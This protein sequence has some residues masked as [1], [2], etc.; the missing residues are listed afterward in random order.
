[1]IKDCVVIIPV[2]KSEMSANERISFKQNLA[3]LRQWDIYIITYE[4]LDLKEYFD[5]ALSINKKISVKTFAQDFYK[6]I[7]GYNR[8]LTNVELYTSFNSYKY[9]LVCQ[10]DVYLFRDDLF[11]W[12]QK[13]YDFIGPP[14]MSKDKDGNPQYWR[15]G[16]GGYS[17]RKVSTFIDLLST[18]QSL[19]KSILHD[20]LNILY[21]IKSY[22]GYLRIRENQTKRF[23][24]DIKNEDVFFAKNI[25]NSWK[26]FKVP[27]MEEARTF[28]FDEF[29]QKLYKDNN[30]Q[31]PMG[32]HAWWR[33]ERA[34]WSTF[35]KS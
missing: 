23:S 7:A 29:P 18:Y 11:Q 25:Q 2:Y 31:L 8:L 27:S 30:E 5:I 15:V 24:K 32:V 14:L 1:M 26:T 12:I 21:Q 19:L 28:G 6:N 13:D 9:M 33:F 16:N 4:G 34:F 20:P 10:L 22:Y 35:I 17:L 3:I